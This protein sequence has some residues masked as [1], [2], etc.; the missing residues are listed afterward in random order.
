MR[1]ADVC[2]FLKLADVQGVLVLCV[3][4]AVG[5]KTRTLLL[6]EILLSGAYQ[7]ALQ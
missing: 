5:K 7:A 1:L 6:Q 4:F 3:P 2:C